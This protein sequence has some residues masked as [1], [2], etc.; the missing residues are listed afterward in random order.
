MYLALSLSRSFFSLVCL[1]LCVFYGSGSL[2]GVLFKLEFLLD[3]CARGWV[4]VGGR[5][6]DFRYVFMM[7]FF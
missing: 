6:V 1:S 7:R 3:V 2:F 5:C 4:R